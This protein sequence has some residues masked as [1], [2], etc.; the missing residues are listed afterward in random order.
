MAMTSFD[1]RILCGIDGSAGSDQAVDL[2]GALPIRPHD[3]VIVASR[4]PYLFMTRA[5]DEGLIA[6]ATDA[7][8]E[9]ARADV[10]AAVARLSHSGVRARGILCDGEDAVDALLRAAERESA[11]IIVVGSRGHGAWSSIL[12]GSVA[13]ALAITSPAPVLVVRGRPAPPLRVI[14]A[15]DGSPAARAALDAFGRLPQSEG[16][17]VELVHVL[18]AHEWGEGDDE[19]WGIRESVEHDEDVRGRALLEDQ[20]RLMPK[21]LQV[22]THL[23]RGHVGETLLGRAKDQGAD[24][25]VLGTRGIAGPRKLFFGSTAER[26]LTHAHCNVLVAPAPASA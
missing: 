7:A 8:R 22:R 26:V 25:I 13:R 4:P 20:A 12:L 3:E 21:G 11:S 15:T 2:V 16:C 5:G 24:L 18:E 23:A 6:R 19:T 10:D 17:V 9:R 1:Y 14:V